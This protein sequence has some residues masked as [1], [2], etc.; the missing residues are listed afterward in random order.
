M[1]LAR[2]IQLA[3]N[4]PYRGGDLGQMIEELSMIVLNLKKSALRHN[5]NQD[6]EKLK[7]R[8]YGEVEKYKEEIKFMQDLI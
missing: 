2:I 8:Y 6:N 5:L 3:H 7:A 4:K 1:D